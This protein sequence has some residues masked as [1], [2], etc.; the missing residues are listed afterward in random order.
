[1]PELA[2]LIEQVPFLAVPLWLI[3]IARARNMWLEG[4]VKKAERDQL[5]LD[6]KERL[7]RAE[8]STGDGSTLSGGPPSERPR[9]LGEPDAR[10]PTAPGYSF[11]ARATPEEN[12]R[13]QE[14][15]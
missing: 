14:A 5:R 6:L 11:Q 9:R 7:E 8:P 15:A 13:E 10:P 2:A 4:D 3:G 12:R 1:M